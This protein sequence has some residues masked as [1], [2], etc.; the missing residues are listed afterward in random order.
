MFP[1]ATDSPRKSTGRSSRF[2]QHDGAAGGKPL[3]GDGQAAGSAAHDDRGEALANVSLSL[4]HRTSRRGRRLAL[5][6]ILSRPS[7][8][9]E[10][11]RSTLAAMAGKQKSSDA[12]DPTFEERLAAL[13]AVVEALEGDK[14][15]LE[16]SLARYREGMEHLLAC[17]AL[18]DGAE[19]RLLELL[20]GPGGTAIERPFGKEGE[21]EGAG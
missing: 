7:A 17:R 2:E 14:L 18:L 8:G 4:R 12:K 3:L 16:D 5:P 21:A 20:E 13:E 15:G 6:D 1:P 11:R 10:V 9:R 19:G